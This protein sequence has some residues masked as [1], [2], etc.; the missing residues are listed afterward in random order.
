MINTK[1]LHLPED[2]VIPDIVKHR[3]RDW[4]L[5]FFIAQK[6]GVVLIPPT[7]FYPEHLQHI[8]SDFLRIAYCKQPETLEAAGQRLLKLKPYI[9]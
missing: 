9:K 7:D 5:A 2:W 6:A 4:H 8:G 3:T 1:R